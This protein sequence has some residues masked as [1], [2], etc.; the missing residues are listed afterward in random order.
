MR[1]IPQVF[2]FIDW[3]LPAF[4]AGGPI[5][6]ISNIVNTLHQE[7]EFHIITS[8]RDQ[9]DE[10]S[11]QNVKLNKW[12]TT[13]QYK[14]IYLETGQRIKSIKTILE[15]ELIDVVYF[16]SAFSFHFTILP[17]ILIKLLNKKPKIIIAPRGMFGKGALA[18]KPLKKR[19]FLFFAKLTGLYNQVLWHATNE[20]ERKNIANV[21]GQEIQFKIAANI[22][23][24]KINK[25]KIS[26]KP[27]Q[28][29]LV[30]LSRISPKKNLKF[31]LDLLQN[32]NRKGIQLDIYGPIEDKKYWIKCRKQIKDY[33]LP[34]SYKGELNP[35]MVQETLTN[36]HFFI[37]P[38]LHENFG[39]VIVEALVAGC[40]LI[41][42]ENT[43]WRNLKEKGIGVVIPLSQKKEWEEALIYYLKQDQNEYWELRENCYRYALNEINDELHIEA[44]RQLFSFQ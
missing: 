16:N 29:K 5:K 44:T 38:T 6:S 31:I 41:L 23:A 27:F 2:I 26:K 22:S 43:P 11:F 33:N 36:Y 34:V 10:T 25:I 14:I 7:Y 8:D 3:Y 9:G 32:L 39:H 28:L 21:I 1:K 24:F 35:K 42:S 18:I 19:I 37:L 17:L 15:N 12:F 30:F 20:I 13:P 4:K 40:G